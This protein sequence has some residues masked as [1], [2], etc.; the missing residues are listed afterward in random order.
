MTLLQSK[1][2]SSRF[3]LFH[4]LMPFKVQRILLISTAY[5]AWIMEED[6]RISEQIITEYRGLNLSR[7]P[8]LTWAASFGDVIDFLSRES[9]DLIVTFS[10]YI[11]EKALML[12]HEIK[13]ITP[14]IPVAL[15]VYTD[16]PVDSTPFVW[17]DEIS[18]IERLFCWT[19]QAE[20]FLAI[21]KSIEDKRNALPDTT[22]AGVRIILLV[23]DSPYYLSIIL[24][25]LY[26]ELVIETQ[27]V[28]DDSL[29]EEHRLLSMRARPKILLAY[30]YE[31]AMDIYTQFKQNILG[32]ISDTRFFRHGDMA[33]DAG[34]QLLRYIKNDR[35]DIPLLLTSSEPRNAEAASQVPAA[36]LDKNAPALK[37]N[38]KGFLV[39]DLGFGD[40]IF[41]MPDGQ[42]IDQ[43]GNLYLLEKKLV[44]IPLESFRYHC[45]R[46]DFSRWLYTLA[47]VELASLIRPLSDVSFN[48]LESHRKF[49]VEL[50]RDK[51]IS[52]QQDVIVSFD[53]NRYE[54]DINFAKTGHGSLGGKARGLAFFLTQIHR[55]RHL[56][57]RCQQ[58]ELL[59]PRTLVVT[60]DA[61]DECI[62]INQLA[63]LAADDFPDELIAEKFSTA[64]LPQ[65]LCDQL[66]GFVEQTTCP[67]AVRSSSVLEDARFTSYAGMYHTALLANN[68]AEISIRYTQL[69]DAV[70]RVYASTYF[71]V[72]KSLSKR[73][74]NRVEQEKMA[75]IIQELVGS[76]HGSFFYPAIS[77]V[78]QSH[79]YYPFSQMKTED[80]ILSIVLG[81]G[82]LVMEGGQALRFSPRFPQILPQRARV[83]DILANS[84]QWFYALPLD[85][86]RQLAKRNLIEAMSENPVSSLC[87]SYLLEEDR[88][89]DQFVAGS[90]PLVT[91]ASILKYSALPL[92]EIMQILLDLGSKGMGCPVEIEFALDFQ[93]GFTDARL[94][95][96]Q[97]RPMSKREACLTVSLG[98]EDVKQ[99]FCLSHQALGNTCNQEMTDLV[100]VRPDSFDP[101]KTRMIAGEISVLNSN[102]KKE[103][104]KYI[105]IGPGRWGSADSWLGIPV[106]WA[107]IAMV[108]AIVETKHPRIQADPSQGSHFFH[109]ITALAISYL[110][111][112]NHPDDRL[113]W[114]WLLSQKRLQETEHLLHIRCEKAVRLLVDGR[115]RQG[116]LVV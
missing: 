35:F 4:E 96:L 56:F 28:I 48:S 30:S 21:I 34:L 39:N 7:P 8:R 99:A 15:L 64:S 62:A 92:P 58:V 85:G 38:I 14:D 74:G 81:F 84:Q 70:R 116:L 54:P 23:E 106:N 37:E 33:D 113:D 49:L 69:I 78:A 77:G 104:R 22:S 82:K 10:P 73:V 24:P 107:D 42:V 100:V 12:G 88:I 59:V 16:Q 41:K 87:S 31:Q 29:N 68:D 47:E 36:F 63:Y 103:G 20:L 11:N 6:A 65:S 90:I 13:K 2:L 45:L 57:E 5:E 71:R 9:F 46:N 50:I 115:S 3:K 1:K 76:R 79:N 97:I 53:P 55:N 94:A 110:T 95:L 52:R 112:G 102:L 40:F 93:V 83:Q 80:G 72:P 105:L 111:V 25:L 19:G 51:R 18:T 61:F 89:R 26:K 114:E 67:L 101:A 32:V 43:A 66:Y 27:T 86:S 108:G 75:I 91:F 109:T 17:H 60:T 98:D 44:E